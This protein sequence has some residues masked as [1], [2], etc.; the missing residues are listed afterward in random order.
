MAD[1][2]GTSFTPN[3]EINSLNLQKLEINSEIAA[4]Y[5]IN[6]IPWS[7]WLK[8]TVLPA[9]IV[10]AISALKHTSIS[11]DY[12][13]ENLNSDAHWIYE[14][15][16]EIPEHRYLVRH[17]FINGSRG[18]WKETNTKRVVSKQ[19]TI[20]VNQY[21][22][23]INT[24]DKKRNVDLINYEFKKKKIFGIGR[25]GRWEHMNSD[26]A[27]SEALVFAKKLVSNK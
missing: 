27:V 16:L 4:D 22:Y 9:N 21:A 25:W 10:Q 14:P 17:N 6:T 26:V 7:E 13:S 18:Y 2:L 11:I 1:S 20:H 15:S 23:P 12:A 3:Y 5:I 19:N 24:I 8:F